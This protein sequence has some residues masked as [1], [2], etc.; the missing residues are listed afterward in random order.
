MRQERLALK[1][2]SLTEGPNCPFLLSSSSSE[3]ALPIWAGP[4]PSP[5]AKPE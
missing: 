3:L 5:S 2:G 1:K 4:D